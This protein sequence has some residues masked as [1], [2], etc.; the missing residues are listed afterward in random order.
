M[1]NQIFLLTWSWSQSNFG[2]TWSTSVNSGQTW[3]TLVQPSQTSRNVPP[4][5]FWEPFDVIEPLSGQTRLNPGRHVLCADTQE[6]PGGK[7][8]IMTHVSTLIFSLSL[9]CFTHLF[10]RLTS[11]STSPLHLPLYIRLTTSI[12]SPLHLSPLH[13][14]NWLHPQSLIQILLWFLSRMCYV[15]PLLFTNLICRFSIFLIG[16]F[17]FMPRHGASAK[18]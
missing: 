8:R 13:L 7:N 15:F 12:P 3:S 18:L 6:N 16:F 2:Q 1:V 4:A 14:P 5:M 9:V 10:L 17:G 11:S